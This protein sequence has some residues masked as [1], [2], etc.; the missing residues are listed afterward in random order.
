M[1]G[2]HTLGDVSNKPSRTGN[3]ERFGHTRQLLLTIVGI[4]QQLETGPFRIDH[5]VH[6]G[7]ARNSLLSDP[8]SRVYPIVSHMR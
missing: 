1:N 3:D 7:Y 6:D 4:C 8:A 2:R 5:S